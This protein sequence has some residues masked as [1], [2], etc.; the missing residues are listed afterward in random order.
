MRVKVR[1]TIRLAVG[2]SGN[3]PILAMPGLAM[4][5]KIAELA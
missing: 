2:G 4:F 3:V 1:L 5:D